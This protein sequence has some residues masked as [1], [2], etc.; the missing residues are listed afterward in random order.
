MHEF[1]QAVRFGWL[2][3]DHSNILWVRPVLDSDHGALLRP[4]LKLKLFFLAIDVETDTPRS[5]VN[6]GL[7]SAKEWTPQDEWRLLP[8]VHVQHNEVNRDEEIPYLHWNILHY[9]CRVTD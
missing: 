7:C 5:N 6:V 8:C 2:Y 9:P 4:R 1:Y 3:F